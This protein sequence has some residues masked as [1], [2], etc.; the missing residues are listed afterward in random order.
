MSDDA[1]DRADPNADPAH[2][3]MPPELRPFAKPVPIQ[4]L[5]AP[6]SEARFD[7][8][9]G[10]LRL[11]NGGPNA[12]PFYVDPKNDPA[13]AGQTAPKSVKA[14]ASTAL[15]V[16]EAAVRS[17]APAR[18]LIVPDPVGEVDI[19]PFQG[20]RRAAREGAQDNAPVAPDDHDVTRDEVTQSMREQPP[21]MAASPWAKEATAEDVR[22]SALPSSL[23]PREPTP[24]ADDSPAAS[25]SRTTMVTRRPPPRSTATIAV[26]IVVVA[27]V[28]G[29]WAAAARWSPESPARGPAPTSST[30]APAAPPT[31]SLP[32]SAPAPASAMASPSDDGP[33]ASP[34]PA[35]SGAPAP[36]SSHPAPK[37]RPRGDDP[38]VETPLVPAPAVTTPSSAAP[39]APPP[40][41]PSPPAP[42][43]APVAPSSAPVAPSSTHKAVGGTRVF[44]D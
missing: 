39:V 33:R 12:D 13:F 43:S 21:E 11:L 34:P 4:P 16:A 2:E 31:P 35:P 36:E 44:G 29:V 42:S 25:P 41:P 1:K 26:A 19:R 18:I 37:R 10:A 20:V 15:P 32:P 7:A 6:E 9:I 5:V 27:A 23:R 8:A 28:I 38:H 22:G 14:Y 24:P 40:T 17:A 30:V 3:T